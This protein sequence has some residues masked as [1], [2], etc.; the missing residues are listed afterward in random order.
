MNLI[1]R[2][3]RIIFICV[4]SM[5]CVGMFEYFNGRSLLGSDGMFGLWEGDIYS[6]EQSQRLF[7]PY[8]FTHFL[9]GFLLYALMWL[10]SRKLPTKY[11]LVGAVILEGLW[12]LLENS[13]FIINRYRAETIAI[14]YVGDSI[15]NSLSD[16]V[17]MVIGFLTASRLKVWQ[18]IVIF[19]AI[20]IFLLFWIRDNLILN[21]IMLI[22][23]SEAIKNWQKMI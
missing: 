3:Y 19:V 15:L 8:S 9:H 22:Y 21:V 13:S 23:P 4:V 20:E 14:G 10:V 2:Y 11:R 5:L 6:N 18:S 7:D 16:I 12:E 1:I 17:M